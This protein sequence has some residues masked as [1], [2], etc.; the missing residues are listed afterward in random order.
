MLMTGLMA[1]ADLARG[2]GKAVKKILQAS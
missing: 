1:L 2:T